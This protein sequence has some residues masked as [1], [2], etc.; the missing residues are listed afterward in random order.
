VPTPHSDERACVECHTP[1]AP[2]Q[3]YCLECGARVGP[4]PV[5]VAA[6][7]ATAAWSREPD[8]RELED[9]DLGVPPWLPLTRVAPRAAALAVLGLLAFGVVVGSLVS[10]SA[11]GDA[12]APMI[13]AMGP[14]AAA[15][16]ALPA[17]VEPAAPDTGST[18]SR[19]ASSTGSTPRARRP[20]PPTPP[21]RAPPTRRPC[22]P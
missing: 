9:D 16:A 3:R 11:Q 7:I 22:P 17:P 14:A 21:A 19:P 8:A 4:L 20:P 2:D 12:S 15:P 1:L 5:H 13:V 10:P 6:A 18:P